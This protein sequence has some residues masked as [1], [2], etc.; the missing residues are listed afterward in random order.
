MA[1]GERDEAE[2][3]SDWYMDRYMAATRLRAGIYT[4]LGHMSVLSIYP[5]RSYF[6]VHTPLYIILIA[7]KTEVY[8]VTVRSGN[9]VL[10]TDNFAVPAVPYVKFCLCK[11]YNIRD[12]TAELTILGDRENAQVYTIQGDRGTYVTRYRNYKAP[13]YPE[14]AVSKSMKWRVRENEKPEYHTRELRSILDEKLFCWA[15]NS[16]C[17]K[18]VYLSFCWLCSGAEP[19]TELVGAENAVRYCSCR[20]T[21]ED[22]YGAI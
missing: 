6:K 4:N 1:T 9:W 13:K 17:T 7:Q 3:Y 14:K 20:L 12:C 10:F 15:D 19:G 16:Y 22:I 21:L 8:K 11:F 2:E 5:R 18:T